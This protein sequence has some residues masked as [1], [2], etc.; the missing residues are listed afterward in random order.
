MKMQKVKGNEN[1]EEDDVDAD[2]I[3]YILRFTRKSG[4]HLVDTSMT[5]SANG[6]KSIIYLQ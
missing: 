1:A 4:S 3:K 5:D 6:K 2:N